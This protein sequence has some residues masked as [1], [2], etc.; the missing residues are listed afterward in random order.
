MKNSVQNIS[1]RLQEDQET[2][3][4]VLFKSYEFGK[5]TDAT[6]KEVPVGSTNIL[7]QYPEYT[8]GL[9][10]RTRES[11]R[12][13]TLSLDTLKPEAVRR[14]LNKSLV[15]PE[16]VFNPVKLAKDFANGLEI[17]LKEGIGHIFA[18]EF[19]I[20]VAPLAPRK[21]EDF[22]NAIVASYNMHKDFKENGV[23][24]R[25]NDNFR[26]YFGNI[27]RY[28]I[29]QAFPKDFSAILSACENAEL[30]F[31]VAKLKDLSPA[32]KA[33]IAVAINKI[34][35]ENPNTRLKRAGAGGQ[36]LTKGNNYIFRYTFF[37]S[38]EEVI[39]MEEDILVKHDNTTAVRK[40]RRDLLAGIA[41]TE[42]AEE[43][44]KASLAGGEE[45][46]EE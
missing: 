33:K 2:Q 23:V 28:G 29:R 10:G 46:E 9:G 30:V 19:A 15:D 14:F 6:G 32:H 39:N 41:T 20:P 4:L 13:A 27:C 17:E 31:D 45:E 5:T 22:I 3:S 42:E 18:Q 34:L 1:V 40:Q 37:T 36:F 38:S 24:V 35:F 26:F 7:V 43:N 11:Y 21:S 12:V 25:P 8:I 44:A 16:Y